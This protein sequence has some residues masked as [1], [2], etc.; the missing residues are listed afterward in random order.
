VLD[1][2]EWQVLEA[3]ARGVEVELMEHL[4]NAL[5]APSRDLLERARIAREMADAKLRSAMRRPKVTAPSR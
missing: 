1:I 4:E 3:R 2:Q 5:D